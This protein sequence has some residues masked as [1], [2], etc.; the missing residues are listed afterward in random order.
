MTVAMLLYIEDIE[1]T[2]AI[3]NMFHKSGIKFRFLEMILVSKLARSSLVL[4]FR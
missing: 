2:H 4:K 1:I 3:Y